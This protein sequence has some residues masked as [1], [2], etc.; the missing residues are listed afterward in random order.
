M[1]RPRSSVV[2]LSALMAAAS[3][4]ASSAAA[5]PAVPP[6]ASA[7]LKESRRFASW[8]VLDADVF[9]LIAGEG[10]RLAALT[11]EG[12][13]V[14]PVRFEGGTWTTIALPASA[15]ARVGKSALGIYFGRD[16]R[17]RLMGHRAE[18]DRRKMVYLRHR[19]GVWQDQRGEIGA[20]AGDDAILY[21]VLGEEDPEVVCKVG[22]I[23]LLKSRKGWKQ[24]PNAVPETAV[25]RVFD[26]NA[27]ALTA[28]GVL[29]ATDAG[30]VPYGPRAPWR[31]EV[32][33]FSVAPGGVVTVAEPAADVLHVLDRRDATW[34]TER[35]P[36]DGPRDVAGPA[37]ARW[38]GGDGGL[39]HEEDGTFVRPAGVVRPVVRVLPTA[40]G[41][42]VAGKEGVVVV[43]PRDAA[44]PDAPPRR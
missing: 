13:A 35:S 33:G 25:I 2:L 32:T 18:G 42:V 1:A 26:G 21:G 31:S 40:T 36:V 27:Y 24:L 44:R 14:T 20:L 22:S 15:A 5:P 39:A 11:D 9:F 38:V 10:G 7:A 12:G 28:E 4:V 41:C 30:F 23:C 34:R 3:V 29:V 8:R 17:P 19:D 6:A 37:G 43:G 16:N